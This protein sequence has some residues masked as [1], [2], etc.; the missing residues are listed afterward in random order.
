MSQITKGFRAILSHP[1][2]YTAFQ[3]IMGADGF[4][5][6]FVNDFIRPFPGIKILDIGCGTADILNYLDD[7]I[8]YHG[9]DISKPYI[10]FAKSSFPKKG[11][12]Y[13]Q[14]LCTPDLEKLP[15][16]D[17]VLALGLLHHLDDPV[18]VDL[19]QMCTKALKSGGR[20]LTIDPCLE[21]KQNPIARFLVKRDRGQ[22]VRTSKEYSSL[23]GSVFDSFKLQV[24]HQTWIPYTHCL[25]ECTAA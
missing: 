12:F 19:L 9:F 18:A 21:P 13:C 16:F 6:S 24:R 7:S 25:M 5:N 4:R 10:D 1:K 8:E 3:N 15:S 23:V 2:V 14:E 17:V 22:N 20:L 11:T